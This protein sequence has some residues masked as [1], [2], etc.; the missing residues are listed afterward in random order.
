[1]D[2]F[3]ILVDTEG[4]WLEVWKG[5]QIFPATVAVL[6]S[7]A[8]F[9]PGCS[10]QPLSAQESQQGGAA[11]TRNSFVAKVFNSD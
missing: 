11:H 2:A 9:S 6:L 10:L 3:C 4:A 7:S 5:Q 8:G 1:M